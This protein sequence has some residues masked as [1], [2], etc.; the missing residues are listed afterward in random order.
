MLRVEL[1]G[2][3]VCVLYAYIF[4]HNN[5]PCVGHE[6]LCFSYEEVWEREREEMM[7]IVSFFRMRSDVVSDRFLLQTNSYHIM[8]DDNIELVILFIKL[9]ASNSFNNF[10]FKINSI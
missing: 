3:L 10:H 9:K 2:L 7:K 1:N 5:K 8:Y 4:S 6:Q